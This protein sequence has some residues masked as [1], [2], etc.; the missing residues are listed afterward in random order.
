MPLYSTD[1][2][3]KARGNNDDADGKDKPAERE[4][5]PDGECQ[6]WCYLFVHHARV[7]MVSS[8]LGKQFNTFIHK[9]TIYKKEN[10]RIKK[11]ERQTISGLIF[12]QGNKSAIQDFLNRNCPGAYLAKDCSTKTTAVIPDKAMRSFMHLDLQ[13]GRIRFMPH[14]LGYYSEGHPLVRITSG[15]LAGFEGYRIRISRNKCLVTSI[16]GITVAISGI[17]NESFEDVDEYIK[18]RRKQ[19]KVNDTYAGVTDGTLREIEECFFMPQSQFDVV[20]IARS[21]WQKV[22]TARAHC[23][24]GDYAKAADILIVLVERTVNW[25]EN[26]AGG[27]TPY[28]TK[29]VFDACSEACS[30]LG[31]MAETGHLTENHIK[32]INETRLS[33]ASK[34][35]ALASNLSKRF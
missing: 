21:L 12:V 19:Q 5:L 32:R 30:L 15:L 16:G 10:K 17:N 31:Q 18:L 8:L 3:S 23:G 14:P 6:A 24:N 26:M 7:S 22:D 25:A 34:Y 4:I 27:M 13:G 35:P 28:N 2:H 20:A 33:L 9:T 1:I 29:D 11:Q